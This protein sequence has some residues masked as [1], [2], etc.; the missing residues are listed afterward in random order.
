V[1]AAA[2]T[3]PGLGSTDAAAVAASGSTVPTGELG[4]GRSPVASDDPFAEMPFADKPEI[5]IGIA[6]A[7][8]FLLAKV[9]KAI[10]S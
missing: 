4:P 8:T 7:S 5:Q 9:L 3:S 10:V 1:S 2:V 6:F